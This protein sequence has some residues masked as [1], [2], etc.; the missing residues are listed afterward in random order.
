MVRPDTVVIRDASG[1]IEL[2][3][4]SHSSFDGRQLAVALTEP[5]GAVS[6]AGVEIQWSFERPGKLPLRPPSN[7]QSSQNPA[8]A[9]CPAHSPNE[10][11][12]M[13]GGALRNRPSQECVESFDAAKVGGSIVLRHW[14]P[15][16]RFQPIGMPKPVKLQDMFVNRKVPRAN[17]HKLLVA[18]TAAGEIMWVEGLRISECFKLDK[19][20]RRQLK[21]SWRRV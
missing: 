9:A 2:Q 14:Q 1:G 18:A 4:L 8:H 10:L 19:G 21:L 20:S 5:N 15:G 11:R 3:H 17:R 12:C 13:R 16:D 7:P 6:F